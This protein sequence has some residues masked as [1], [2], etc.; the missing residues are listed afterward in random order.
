MQ[1]DASQEKYRVNR[2]QYQGSANIASSFDVV[3][4]SLVQSRLNS[5]R[6]SSG[7]SDVIPLPRVV[8]INFV[9]LDD[10]GRSV[11]AELDLDFR[12]RWFLDSEVEDEKCHNDGDKE[13]VD[14]DDSQTR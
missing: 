7:R 8:R 2:V 12:N 3:N 11:F 4:D 14:P 5:I 13:R 10:M 9:E 6:M 1:Y